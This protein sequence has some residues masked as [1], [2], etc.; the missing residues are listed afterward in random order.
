MK[1]GDLVRKKS[2]SEWVGRIVG[3]YSTALTPEGYA[4]ESL[5]HAGSVQIYPAKALEL[6]DDPR[7]AFDRVRDQAR[8]N[9]LH[10]GDPLGQFSH[11][12][13]ASSG[14]YDSLILG[15]L[16][17]RRVAIGNCLEALTIIAFQSGMKAEDCLP[18]NI[19]K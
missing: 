6:T 8:E 7:S 5:H 13:E 1:I 4:V 3:T 9:N 15:C 11:L 18:T 17:Y 12:L 14:L 2:G 10:E 19:R 16:S